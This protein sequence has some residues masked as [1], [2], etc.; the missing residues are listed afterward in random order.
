VLGHLQVISSFTI[1]KKKKKE[2]NIY[3]SRGHRKPS[4]QDL[5]MYSPNISTREPKFLYLTELK[6]YTKDLLRI[7]GH[8]RLTT[9]KSLKATRPTEPEEAPS[10]PTPKL[11]TRRSDW[12]F[13]HSKDPARNSAE[14]TCFRFPCRY[15]P[16]PV[17]KF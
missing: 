10:K 13:Q 1:N 8:L 7:P 9:K 3:Y 2:K 4:N 14:F 17:S 6:I 15:F 5:I 12:P 16:M 11:N